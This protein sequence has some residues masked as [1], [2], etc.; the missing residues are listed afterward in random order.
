[1]SPPRPG[2]TNKCLKAS[3]NGK[4]QNPL[5]ILAKM[6]AFEHRENSNEDFRCS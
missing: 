1:M 5:P 3:K 6:K 4:T 2:G